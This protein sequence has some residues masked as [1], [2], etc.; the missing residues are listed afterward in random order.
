MGTMNTIVVAVEP[1]ADGGYRITDASGRAHMVSD[2]VDLGKTI[3]RLTSDSTLPPPV[4][5]APNR[6]VGLVA[7]VVR[8]FAPHHAGLVD[9]VEPTV[10]QA[11]A[12]GIRL[13]ES[14]GKK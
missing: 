1:L 11:T 13:A 8:R 12:L 14:R 3:A 10:H 7:S 2:E 6:M 5:E 9:A 4:V